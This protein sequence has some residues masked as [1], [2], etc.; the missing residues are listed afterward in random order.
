M[1]IQTFRY[2]AMGASNTLL[3]LIT[4]YIAYHF[5]FNEQMLHLGFYAF[6]SY[7]ASLAISFTVALIWGFFVMKY[8]VFDDST[9]RGHVQFFRYF[10]VN[11][12]NLFFNWILLKL[13][14]EL[15]HIYPTFAQLATTAVLIVFS[16]VAQRHFTFKKV[17]VPD[18]IEKDDDEPAQ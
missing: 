6:E 17:V 4:F 12:L 15:L 13:A 16:Y 9:I 1:P 2:L 7:T 3:G 8:V 5:I 14:V 11:L 18:Y 10:F